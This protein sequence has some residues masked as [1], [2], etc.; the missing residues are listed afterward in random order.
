MQKFKQRLFLKKVEKLLKT[1]APAPENYD[2][3]V[4]SMYVGATAPRTA[5]H[6]ADSAV[7]V[8][9]EQVKRIAEM[10]VG[11]LGVLEGVGEED[12][13]DIVKEDMEAR[14]VEVEVRFQELDLGLLFTAQEEDERRSV[15][16]ARWK[17]Q[18]QGAGA[19]RKNLSMAELEATKSQIS[20]WQKEQL[21]RKRRLYKIENMVRDLGVNINDPRCRALDRDRRAG[22]GSL[23]ASTDEGVRML[24]E[25]AGLLGCGMG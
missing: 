19:R 8:R 13:K 16:A 17:A 12:G 1:P 15:A 20:Q 3:T 7:S 14:L 9:Q 21:Q 18:A 11:I 4:D 25:V 22:L 2:S 10:V 6:F 5:G 23:N 24:R